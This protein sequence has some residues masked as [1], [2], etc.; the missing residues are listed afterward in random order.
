MNR[1]TFLVC[2]GKQISNNEYKFIGSKNGIS[3]CCTNKPN[4]KKGKW[5]FEISS[6]KG[7]SNKFFVALDVK[8]IGYFGYY[9]NWTNNE[10]YF[11]CD[12][13]GNNIMRFINEKNQYFSY[14]PLRFN[15]ATAD[16]TA[17][18]GFDFESRNFYLRIKENVRIQRMLFNTTKTIEIQPYI[19]EIKAENIE[20]TI[21]A[22][23]GQRDFEYDVPFGFQP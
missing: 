19:F 8:D 18:I 10:Q 7:E 17:G 2:N 20:D 6:K 21:S 16:D 13:R 9:P 3:T 12:S 4:A 15:D 14:F 23:F 1:I 22:N 5:Y 11:Y